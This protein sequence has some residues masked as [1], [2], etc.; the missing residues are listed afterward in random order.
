MS[1]ARLDYSFDRLAIA[2]DGN[3]FYYKDQ[4]LKHVTDSN[5]GYV[6]DMV[7]IDGYFVV[8]DG[9][10]LVVTELND[11]TKVN[12]YKYGSSEADP[13]PI[14][15]VL[16]IRNELYAVNR[17]TTEVFQN[18]GGEYFP[19][20]RIPGALIQR[21]TIGTRTACMF[22]DNLAF[23]GGGRNESISVWLGG[24]GQSS[25]ISTREIDVIL[26]GYTEEDLSICLLEAITVDGFD[27][28]YFHLPDKT[29]VYN[30]TASIMAKTPI[31]LILSSGL[32]TPG[33]G[34]YLLRNMVFF[35]NRWIG[36]HPTSGYLGY[37]DDAT[38]KHWDQQV[39]W[40]FNTTILYNENKGAIIHNMELVI[41]NKDMTNPIVYTAHSTD[42]QSWSFDLPA[43][44]K[45]SATRLV[46]RR[47]GRMAQKRIQRFRGTETMTVAALDA[48]IEPLY[49]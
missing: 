43:A 5:L 10:Y 9:S 21:G 4:Q 49:V 31:W 2:I 44:T 11:P 3:L 16:K 38:N 26:A 20:Q 40:Q 1:L 15:C 6:K 19:F 17:Y 33:E 23:V 14:E 29:L 24:S 34:R 41:K 42:G 48:T 47:L 30:G 27:Y 46:W 36:G 13:D 35:Y 32:N 39:G 18:T 25:R 8:T 28:L 22:M 45:S 37:L 12:P 7:W